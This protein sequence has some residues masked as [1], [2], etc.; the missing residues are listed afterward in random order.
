MIMDNI[1]KFIGFERL[2]EYKPNPIVSSPQPVKKQ[3]ELL[4]VIYAPDPRTGLPSSDVAMLM[5]NKDNPEVQRYIQ[6]RIQ[7]H[8]ESVAGAQSP[9]DAIQAIRKYREDVVSYANR[10]RDGFNPEP[11][12]EEGE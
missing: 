8:H 2:S 3:D 10:L 9:D 12:S 5:K 7:I 1:R 6:Q 11:T 4:S